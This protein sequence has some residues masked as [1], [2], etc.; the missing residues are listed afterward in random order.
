MWNETAG[1]VGV[2]YEGQDIEHFINDLASWGIDTLVDVR[3][4][5]ISR[6][7][8]FSKNSLR[9]ALEARGINYRHEPALGNPKD[10]RDGYSEHGTDAGAAARAR[11]TERLSTDDAEQAMDEV[12]AIASRAHVALMCFEASELHC[13]RREALKELNERLSALSHA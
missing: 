8:G 6:K 10:N 3:L 13:H 12:A 5:P 7:R 2:G 4:N 1:A 11:Y 9:E